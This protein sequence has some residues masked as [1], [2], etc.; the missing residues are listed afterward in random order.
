MLGFE[1]SSGQTRSAWA[2]LW[3]FPGGLK[4][5]GEQGAAQRGLEAHFLLHSSLQCSTRNWGMA[6]FWPVPVSPLLR[7]RFGIRGKNWSFVGPLL[8]RSCPLRG[9]YLNSLLA[10]DSTS[11]QPPALALWLSWG[12]RFFSGI[13]AAPLAVVSNYAPLLQLTSDGEREENSTRPQSGA[14]VLSA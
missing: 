4:S 5:L 6:A 14:L 11:A 9:R 1:K 2:E 10:R 3:K 7:H 8:S 13:I 12:P